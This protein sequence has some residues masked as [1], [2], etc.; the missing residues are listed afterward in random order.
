[1]R[2]V[3]T[4]KIF[5]G[6]E[7][8][9][10]ISTE[11]RLWDLVEKMKRLEKYI[12]CVINDVAVIGIDKE[13]ELF[14][15][16]Q[17]SNIAVN[18][19][20]SPLKVGSIDPYKPENA[21]CIQKDGMFLAYPGEYGYEIRPLISVGYIS[22]LKRLEMDCGAMMRF[23]IKGGDRLP[24]PV[25][26][27][28]Q[29]LT[30]VA[31]LNSKLCYVITLDG[32]VPGVVSDQY[33]PL[34]YIDL[35]KAMKKVVTK[36]HPDLEFHS[37]TL[38]FEYLM[39]LERV[40]YKKMTK[41]ELIDKLIAYKNIECHDRAIAH[42]FLC[43]QKENPSRMNFVTHRLTDIADP[44][45]VAEEIR[46]VKAERTASAQQPIKDELTD[47]IPVYVTLYKNI[48]FKKR[49]D[50]T[51]DQLERLKEE[52]SAESKEVPITLLDETLNLMDATLDALNATN[53]ADLGYELEY[54]FSYGDPEQP[55]DGS[56]TEEE[57][58]VAEAD[59]SDVNSEMESVL[60][61]WH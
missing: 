35:L 22:I 54:S 45:R 59:D 57:V 23:D 16:E 18:L 55:L 50:V 32:C 10:Q 58:P 19:H 11:D 25:R 15:Q 31:Q 53:E 4:E 20:G 14:L 29:I 60:F 27:K 56:E 34:P 7:D 8:L 46:R 44:K 37:G 47:T 49:F 38:S 41:D 12:P 24:L 36:E 28:G 30:R 39:D 1:M 51:L 33:V 13:Q 2:E 21:I 43:M 6:E 61:D 52:D 26:E 40:L 3:V 17:C 5:S 9:I 48:R 42:E